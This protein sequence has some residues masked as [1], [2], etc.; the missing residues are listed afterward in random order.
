MVASS[1]TCSVTST[2]GDSEFGQGRRRRAHRHSRAWPSSPRTR[3][4]GQVAA[5]TNAHAFYLSAWEEDRHIIAQANA[6]IDEQ[7]NFVDGPRQLPAGGQLHPRAARAGQLHRRLAQAARLGGGLVDSVPRERRRQ[8]RA[9]GLEHAAPGR[10]AARGRSALV[11]TG[12]EHATA[13]D[14]GAVVVARRGGVVDSVDSRAHHRA[15]RSRVPGKRARRSAR[16]STTS[17]SSSA[18][19]RTPA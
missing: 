8:P 12:M 15:N 10:A 13:R 19:T 5:V 7:G 6:K 18:P 2:V 1:I 17:P 4:R 3:R 11:G 16:T 9:H 14:S